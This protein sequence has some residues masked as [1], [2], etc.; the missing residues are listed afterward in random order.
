[1]QDRARL[2]TIFAQVTGLGQA[3]D[4]HRTIFVGQCQAQ[5]NL[6]PG[7]R[8]D[9]ARLVEGYLCTGRYRL[10]GLARLRTIFAQVQDVMAIFL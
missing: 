4:R 2:R 9:R 3:E 8:Q 1:M 7:N 6:C 10:Q 5:D